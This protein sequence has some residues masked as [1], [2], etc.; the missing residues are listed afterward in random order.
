MG[1]GILSAVGKL[2]RGFGTQTETNSES[3]IDFKH[4]EAVERPHLFFQPSFIDGS[5]LFEQ[6]HRI[7]GQAA[8][9]CVETNMC[10]QLGF[11]LPTRNSRCDDGRTKSVA[12]VVLDNQNRTDTA[13]FRTD[14]GA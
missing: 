14:N 1:D 10:G 3:R 7:S 4:I 13:L 2:L 12:D 8:V 9:V 11:G 6:H 5:D